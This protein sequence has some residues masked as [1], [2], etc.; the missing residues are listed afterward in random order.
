MAVKIM[1][2]A[3]LGDEGQLDAFKREVQVLSALRH[4]HIVRLLGACLVLPHLCIVEELA[5]GGSLYDRLHGPAGQRCDCPLPYSQVQCN[6]L[7]YHAAPHA[8]DPALTHTP[9]PPSPLS[10]VGEEGGG[11]GVGKSIFTLA[12]C[13][14]WLSLPSISYHSNQPY[15]PL[16]HLCFLGIDARSS[17]HWHPCLP[18]PPPPRR[19]PTLD[20]LPP[21][22]CANWQTRPDGR[23]FNEK[24]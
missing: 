22:S 20:P 6:E 12:S 24:V 18:P 3:G 10:G 9:P 13:N 2:S 14:V 19:C 11:G 4:P 21:K 17:C 15:Q 16:M 7:R 23:I 1:Q 5:K 8:D